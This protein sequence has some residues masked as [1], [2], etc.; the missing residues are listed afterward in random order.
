MDTGKDKRHAIRKSPNSVVQQL[1]FM[2]GAKGGL[3]MLDRELA[4]RIFTAEKTGKK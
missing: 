2:N 1:K 3:F 4:Q